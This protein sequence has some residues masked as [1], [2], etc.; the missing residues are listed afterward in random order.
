MSLIRFTMSFSKG[1]I[2]KMVHGGLLLEESPK[3]L[4]SLEFYEL[5]TSFILVQFLLS[6]SYFSSKPPVNQSKLFHFL[7]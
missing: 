2:F 7:R 3:G 5:F 1:F 4:F 6:Q